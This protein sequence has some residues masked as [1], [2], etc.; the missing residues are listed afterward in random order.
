MSFK[1][2]IFSD[3][4][5]NTIKAGVDKLADAVKVTLGP[6]G[7]NVVIEKKYG[8]PI[9]T[10]DGVTVAKEID[11]EDPFENMG[12]QMVKEVA[13]KTA[14]VAGDGTTTATVLAQSIYA[15]GLKHVTAGRNPMAI[16]RGI[17][18]AVQEA[19]KG[20]KAV[21]HDLVGKDDIYKVATIS[22]N[23]DEQIGTILADAMEKIG[24]DGAITFE[25]GNTF[26]IELDLVE[27]M[28]FNR[29]YLSPYFVTNEEKRTVELEKPYILLYDSKL[30]NVQ[31]LLP[32]L[33]H[34]QK[35]N[36]PLLI[37]ADEVE[38]E[39]LATLVLNKL[40][41]VLSVCAIKSPG[42]G[43]TK[44][45]M[46]EDIAI[47][48]RGSVIS[49]IKGMKLDEFDPVWLGK[50]HKVLIDKDS[51]MIIDGDGDA[52]EINE[53]VEQLRS[54]IESSNNEYLSSKLQGRLAKLTDGMAVIK[55]GA[56][57]E[58]ALKEK[59][60][61][62]DDAYHATKAAVDEGIVPG[63]GA[64]YLRAKQFVDN[65]N[66][67]DEDERIGVEIVKKA[68]ISP[69]KQI[70]VNAGIDS[71]KII[72]EL[73]SKEDEFGYDVNS[74]K[75]E[76]MFDAGVI[77]PFKVTRSALQNAASIAG[78]LLTTECMISRNDE[79]TNNNA[80]NMP[81]PGFGGMY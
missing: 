76:N 33:E 63:G 53:R 15:E 38:G 51:T 60:A 25:D 35:E 55:I 6:K 42:I 46:M 65:L 72:D 12:A 73:G 61:R 79:D 26:D 30:A 34:V 16:K 62:M 21:Q 1:E 43:D 49:D 71:H 68:L 80:P 31:S 23:N 3:Q 37:I 66:L 45:D 70:L 78:L 2:I 69:I 9:I 81:Q 17:D 64:A 7:R 4:A 56:E 24:R 48:T 50:A 20:L 54:Q 41:G 28:T 74:G 75:I 29:T 18:I 13:S 10:K 5:R 58:I 11:L 77:D 57:T 36:R 8:T 27:G 52:V 32:I 44:N 47:L 67:T 39:A 59:K 40:R 19:V 14:D 22:A